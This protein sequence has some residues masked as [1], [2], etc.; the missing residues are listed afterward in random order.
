MSRFEQFG[1]NAGYVE[2]LFKLYET[3]PT[4]VTPTWR[5]YFDAIDDAAAGAARPADA[6]GS[7]PVYRNG[8]QATPAVAAVAAAAPLVDEHAL[9]AQQRVSEIIGAYRARGHFIAKTNPLS[10]ESV[11]VPLLPDDACQLPTVPPAELNRTVRSGVAG[12]AEAKLSEVIQRLE[13]TYCDSVGFEFMHLRSERERLFLQERIE[14]DFVQ[15][16]RGFSA[17][18]RRNFLRKLVSAEK[19]ESELHRR[20]VGLKRFS[21]EG[22]ETVVPMMDLLLERAA[23][24]GVRE[25]IVGIA[26]RGRLSVLTNVIGKPIHDILDEFED[27]SVYTLLGAGDVKYHLGCEAT[28]VNSSGKEIG[29]RLACNP[30]HLEFVNPMVEGMVRAKQDTLYGR[31]RRSVLA[32]LVHGDAAF[33]G[34]GVVY[35]TLNFASTRGCDTGGTVHIIIN[36]QVG[37]TTNP[38]DSRSSVYCTDMAKGINAPVFHVNMRDPEA[39]CWVMQAAFDF[40]QEFGRDVII[41]VLSY[42]KYGH[43]EGDDPTFTQPRMYAEIKAQEPVWQHYGKV[44]AAEG[45]LTEA[46]VEQ[47]VKSYLERFQNAVDTRQPLVAGECSP[48]RGRLV[49]PEPHT[50]VSAEQLQEIAQTTIS[51]PESFHVHQKLQGILEK[52]AK[53]VRDGAGIDWGMAE[54]LAYGSLLQDGIGVR[55]TG[56]DVGRGTFSHRHLVLTDTEDQHLYCSLHPLTSESVRCEIYNSTLSEC[57]EMGFAFGYASDAPRTLVI[58]EAQFGDFA[59]GAQVIIDQFLSGSEAKWEQLSG[60]SLLL[61]HGFEGQGPEHSSARLERFLQLC[62]ENNMTVC[63][64]SNAA[65][66][67]HLLRRQGL[68]EIRRPLIAFT[69]KSLLRNAEASCALGEFTDGR[70]QKII[71]ENI[72]SQRPASVVL[73]SGKVFYEV[74]AAL[75]K[76]GLPVKLI[77][78]E[79]LYPFPEEELRQILSFTGMKQAFWVQE[80]PQNMG[81]WSY[82]EPHLRNVFDLP[83]QYVGRPVSASPAA[84]SLK[85]HTAEQQGIV[86]RLLEVLQRS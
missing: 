15:P 19:M 73:A 5:T 70:F 18:Q 52:R 22:A 1:Q 37:F 82:V 48:L 45:V 69:P 67:F 78:I 63:V 34:Q 68:S 58:W 62:G 31:D 16:A 71:Q 64:P 2:D 57:G 10:P 51:F 46:D 28:Y 49:G 4:L 30:S 24:E 53:A 47:E 32:I 74:R 65:Q 61:P 17:Q 21:G 56:Q 42:R 7:V 72:S 12:I 11:R 8:Q 77:R 36:N 29:V 66:I 50:A 43:N 59:N 75:K 9:S 26:H 38:V 86:R 13:R 14:R 23:D 27:E 39:A 3:D 44:L 85:R 60:L 80:E 79:Q 41:D 25:A 35:E 83:L 54:A 84:G 76:E 40:R 20:Y 6:G 33:A 81:A 55:L